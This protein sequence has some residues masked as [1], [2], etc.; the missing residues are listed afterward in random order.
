MIAQWFRSSAEAHQDTHW[1]S[2]E[3]VFPERERKTDERLENSSTNLNHQ[4]EKKKASLRHF[5]C[6][7]VHATERSVAHLECQIIYE[8]MI[9]DTTSKKTEVNE[10]RFS[11][12][13]EHNSTHAHYFASVLISQQ[14]FLDM[15]KLKMYLRR[16]VDQDICNIRKRSVSN[17]V[18]HD[19]VEKIFSDDFCRRVGPQ[20][21]KYY[22]RFFFNLKMLLGL[23]RIDLNESRSLTT[24][25]QRWGHIPNFQNYRDLIALKEIRI[26]HLSKQTSW[27]SVISYVDSIRLYWRNRWL[28]KLMF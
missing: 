15:I 24:L 4:G 14:I 9:V 19:V 6:S 21:W 26:N 28:K 2:W 23:Q 11:H 13:V 25:W 5:S 18:A 3:F 27:H 17:S 7:H 12:Y 22:L 1:S 16:R 20:D 8:V 10:F